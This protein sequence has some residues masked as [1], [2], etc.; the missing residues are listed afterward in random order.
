MEAC[1]ILS[2]SILEREVSATFLQN[3]RK[4]QKNYQPAHS[5]SY[6]QVLFYV[7]TASLVYLHLQSFEVFKVL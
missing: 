5:A 3:G 7:Y 1:F 4:N 2:E 6:E